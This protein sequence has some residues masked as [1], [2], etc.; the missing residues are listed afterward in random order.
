MVDEKEGPE[1]PLERPEPT[2]APTRA[3]TPRE[4]PRRRPSMQ[5]KLVGKGQGSPHHAA[6]SVK[7][8]YT[9][10]KAIHRQRRKL[11][12]L[13]LREQGYSFAVI[14]KHMR[15]SVGTVH[16][17]VTE[18]LREIPAETAAEVLR[19]ELQRLDAL[20]SAYYESGVEGDL[21]AAAMALRVADQR[22]R[23]L[24]LYPKEGTGAA[25]AVNVSGNGDDAPF[26][27]IEFV[28][29]PPQPQLEPPRD[30]TPRPRASAD[31][32]VIEGRANPPTSV[33][34]TGRRKGFNWS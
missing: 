23:L 10:P 17:Y 28:P 33:P 8:S 13:Q 32:V 16:G 11:E 9:S 19:L 21:P 6:K 15:C 27:N 30:V 31:P 34:I 14:A 29:P 20:F 4:Q 3:L 7:N 5:R 25:V 12:A 18:A 1:P 22:S 26:V 2:S 24:G